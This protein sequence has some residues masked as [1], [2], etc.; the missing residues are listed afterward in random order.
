MKT[1]G[2][3]I[4]TPIQSK[5][6][7]QHKQQSTNS[8]NSTTAAN[9]NATALQVFARL[10]CLYPR[11]WPSQF[12]TEK[13]REMAKRE[14]AHG[15]EGLTQAEINRG[16]E[17]IAKSGDDWPPSLPEFLAKCKTIP[18]KI[19]SQAYKIHKRSALEKK[20]DP[21]KAGIAIDAM[22]AALNKA[23]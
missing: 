14:W 7:M 15:L 4:A 2:E 13:Q 11:K 19:N 10:Q 16:F 17:A 5:N 3:C 8:N 18:H 21:V 1:I 12:K 20:A 23:S 6:T 9:Y 22:R